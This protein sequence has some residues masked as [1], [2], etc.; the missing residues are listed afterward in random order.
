MS[1]DS[2]NTP[3]YCSYAMKLE[4]LFCILKSRV[5]DFS[6]QAKKFLNDMDLPFKKL[7]SEERNI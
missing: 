5:S 2:E 3:Y 6:F 1:P 4:D 7:N